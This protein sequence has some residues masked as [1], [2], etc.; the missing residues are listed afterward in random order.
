MSIDLTVAGTITINL[1]SSTNALTLTQ[2][3]NSV[4][5]TAI[6]WDA[7]LSDIASLNVTDSNF[8]VG[9]GTN[10]VAE[11]GNTARTSLGLVAGGAGDVWV[12][13]AGDTM[14]GPLTLAEGTAAVGT[15]PLKFTAGTSLATEEAGVLEFDGVCLS[16]IEVL[17][18]RVISMASDSI[19]E[20]TATVSQSETT[21]YTGI[22]SAEELTVGKVIRVRG[23]GHFT[24]HDAS[25]SVTV[26]VKLGTI[27]IAELTSTAGTAETKP[28]HLEANM[29]IRTIGGSGTVSGHGH[30]MMKDKEI[31]EN[32]ETTA[33]DTTSANNV[34]ITA[35]W[36][37]A[38]NHISID[39]AYIEVLN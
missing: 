15:A 10:W 22:V 36:D 20:S 25:D 24:T 18:R 21:I 14:T 8:I 35:E 7:Q 6:Q 9:D 37:D 33:I 31:H 39:Q 5:L 17:D 23:F 29:T 3:S 38:G 11:S 27:T 12:E 19:V 28:W 13:K 32:T 30:I 1:V 2:T 4:A 26:K 16:F 34:T